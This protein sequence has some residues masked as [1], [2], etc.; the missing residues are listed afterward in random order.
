MA[1]ESVAEQNR[2]KLEEH[3]AK[4]KEQGGKVRGKDAADNAK[5]QADP[6]REIPKPP[7]PPPGWAAWKKAHAGRLHT[8]NYVDAEKAAEAADYKLLGVA[9]G[10]SRD[11]I[12]RA[13][14][15]LA[16]ENH[17][18]VGGDAEIFAAIQAAYKRLLKDK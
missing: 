7:P 2:R 15:K 11:E 18:D 13:F 5:R 3:L 6:T 16:K 1:E 17:P 4:L 12:R 10:A 9:P 8:V 14:N